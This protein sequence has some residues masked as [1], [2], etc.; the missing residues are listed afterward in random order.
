MFANGDNSVGRL[1][2]RGIILSE[3]AENGVEFHEAFHAVVEILLPEV[4]R[5]RL[6][7]HYIEQYAHG[8]KVSDRVIAEG[9]ADLYYD[10]KMN[11]PEVK[12]TWNIMK[13]FKNIYEYG[14]ALA[15]LN[16]FRMALMFAATDAGL[17]RAFSINPKRL[18]DI[19][20][21]FGRGLDFTVKD[22]NNKDHVL[23][24]FAN[25]KQ[26]NDL[27]DVLVYK[28]IDKAGIDLLGKNLW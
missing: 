1:N 6:Y 7:K 4:A 18:A 2:K 16:D 27:A 23:K 9:L 5:K 11:T 12:F 17:M 24:Q 25:F 21:R 14:K 10:F 19:D 26:I 3:Y 13:L 20:K 28:L 15:S 22:S 8:H